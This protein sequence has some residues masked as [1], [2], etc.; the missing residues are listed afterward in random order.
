MDNKSKQIRI[1]SEMHKK[2]KI[3]A[4]SEG[5]SIKTFVEGLILKYIAS[6]HG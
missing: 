2:L 4:T 6:S 1:S 3:K 5:K